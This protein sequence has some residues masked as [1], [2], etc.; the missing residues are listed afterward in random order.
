VTNSS[1]AESYCRCILELWTAKEAAAELN[2]WLRLETVGNMADR[3]Q[4]VWRVLRIRNDMSVKEVL[5]HVWMPSR[6]LRDPMY[7]D[8]E[9]AWNRGRAEVLDFPPKTL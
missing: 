1:F 8:A 6:C 5:Q 3:G 4:A 9:D 7:I 2:R